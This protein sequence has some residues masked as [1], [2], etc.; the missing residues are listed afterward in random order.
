MKYTL[1]TT[2][3]A[4]SSMAASANTREA[5]SGA[6][7][8]KSLDQYFRP[9]QTRVTITAGIVGTRDIFSLITWNQPD[10]NGLDPLPTDVAVRGTLYIWWD[11]GKAERIGKKWQR[12]WAG[13]YTEE[14]IPDHELNID[15][16]G[17]SW[18]SG[19]MVSDDGRHKTIGGFAYEAENRSPNVMSARVV[20]DWDANQILPAHRTRH[21]GA[22]TAGALRVFAC[23]PERDEWAVAT[24][25]NAEV[26]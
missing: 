9:E 16:I 25:V 20:I 10:P 12:T 4:F 26:E 11:H 6:L 24:G 15:P 13:E 18:F 17:I 22:L 7:Q 3:L 23:I 21:G 19:L 14:I 8:Q 5:W 1:L 2:I